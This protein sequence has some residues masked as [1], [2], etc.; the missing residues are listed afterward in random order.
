LLLDSQLDKLFKTLGF[1]ITV[2]CFPFRHTASRDAKQISQSALGKS[3]A[4]SE[5]EHGLPKGIV[6]FTVGEPLHRRTLL[7]LRDSPTSTRQW[8][9]MEADFPGISGCCQML[10][11]LHAVQAD[12]E[13]WAMVRDS[14]PDL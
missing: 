1:R 5:C 6:P 4:G 8:E 11:A 10:D 14:R 2:A 13:V 7:L 9:V 3:N 12:C